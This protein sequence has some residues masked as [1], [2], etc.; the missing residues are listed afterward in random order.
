MKISQ[1]ITKLEELKDDHG[2]IPVVID[3]DEDTHPSGEEPITVGWGMINGVT[4]VDI[5]PG[6]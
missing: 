2:D 4:V 3:L 5:S 1:L 6:S